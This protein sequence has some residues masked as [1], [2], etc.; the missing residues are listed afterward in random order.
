MFPQRSWRAG[1]SKRGKTGGYD[2]EAKG[3]NIQEGRN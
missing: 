2:L 3:K 1:Y